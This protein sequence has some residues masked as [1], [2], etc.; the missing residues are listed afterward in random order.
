MEEDD[1][2]FVNEPNLQ[3]IE[4]DD[5]Q[6]VDDNYGPEIAEWVHNVDD[7][8]N[9]DDVDEEN[10][11]DIRQSEDLLAEDEDFNNV[12]LGDDDDADFDA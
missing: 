6:L 5:I 10:I 7:G 8:V 11:R 3:D 1:L 2:V 9:E 12:L 4:E